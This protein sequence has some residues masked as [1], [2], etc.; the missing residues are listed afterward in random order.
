MGK[1]ILRGG[2]PWGPPQFRAPAG[3]SYATEVVK[4]SSISV[5]AH[6]LKNWVKNLPLDFFTLSLVLKEWPNAFTEHRNAS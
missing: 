1:Y 3:G 2:P 4:N 6:E 5:A